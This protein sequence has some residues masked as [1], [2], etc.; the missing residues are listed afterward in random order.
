[1]L[2]QALHV[3]SFRNHVCDNVRLVIYNKIISSLC[4]YCVL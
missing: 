3:Q 4:Y 1:M 2:L